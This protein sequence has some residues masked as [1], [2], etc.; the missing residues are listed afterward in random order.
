ML[1]NAQYSCELSDRLCAATRASIT[2]CQ[3]FACNGQSF[4]NGLPA[5]AKHLSTVCPVKHLPTVCSDGQAFANG[6]PVTAKPAGCQAFTNHCEPLNSCRG[7]PANHLATICQLFAHVSS[8]FHWAHES[9]PTGWQ[10]FANTSPIVCTPLPPG[11]QGFAKG[12]LRLPDY[13]AMISQ[14]V[15]RDLP[16]VCL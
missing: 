12:C 7:L 6:L 2:I 1:C 11:S 8:R 5:T 9:L 15:G 3:R 13:L 10:V 16:T 14:R 4:A